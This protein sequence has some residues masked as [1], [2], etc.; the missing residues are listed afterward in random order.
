MSM[1]KMT[2]AVVSP[3]FLLAATPAWAGVTSVVNVPEPNM[4]GLVVLGVIGAIA[5]SRWRKK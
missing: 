1:L 2:T 4:L 3:I 5:A